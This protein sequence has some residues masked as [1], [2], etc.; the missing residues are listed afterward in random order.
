[1]YPVRY[2]FRGPASYCNG[3]DPFISLFPY[4]HPSRS[5]R[6]LGALRYRRAC[7]SIWRI[8]SLVTWS[9]YTSSEALY[10]E[11]LQ[12]V[13]DGGTIA[14]TRMPKEGQTPM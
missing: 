13:R 2:R 6:V 12:Y 14:S 10:K 9:C 4:R 3:T 7:A 8:R 1:M 5:L 11:L